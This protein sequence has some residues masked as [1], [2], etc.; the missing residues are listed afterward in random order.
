[1]TST[2]IQVTGILESKQFCVNWIELCSRSPSRLDVTCSRLLFQLFCQFVR[3]SVVFVIAVFVMFSLTQRYIFLNFLLLDCRNMAIFLF[4]SVFFLSDVRLVASALRS[5][6]LV[7]VD[8]ITSA[9][10]S[11]DS[12]DHDSRVPGVWQRRQAY[13]CLRYTR[14]E[15]LSVV[16]WR[17]VRVFVPACW[18]CSSARH[19]PRWSSLPQAGEE[20]P[21]PWWSWQA[22]QDYPRHHQRQAG[23]P[24][25]DPPPSHYTD[26]QQCQTS[27]GWVWHEQCDTLLKLNQNWY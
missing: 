2:F 6:G 21:L 27:L 3:Y 24:A 12:L 11:S 20:T 5:P 23:I 22:G 18:L 13:P 15:L 26:L 7:A 16:I 14:D 4:A 8:N 17:K 10:A 1:M 19:R 9:R 25:P